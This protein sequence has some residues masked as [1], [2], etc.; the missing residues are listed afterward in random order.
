MR[1]DRPNKRVVLIVTLPI[2]ESPHSTLRLGGFIRALTSLVPDFPSRL[3]HF[4][5]LTKAACDSVDAKII[6][7]TDEGIEDTPIGSLPT[8]RLLHKK[9]DQRSAAPR[10]PV[11]LATGEAK[12]Q[13]VESSP[14]ATFYRSPLAHLIREEICEPAALQLFYE[15]R[16]PLKEIFLKYAVKPE[17]HGGAF[18]LDKRAWGK[19]AEDYGLISR[20]GRGLIAR[21]IFEEAFDA[22][23]CRCDELSIPLSGFVEAVATAF[24]WH[25][26]LSICS[27]QAE[28]SAL[29]KALFTLAFLHS[30]RQDSVDCLVGDKIDVDELDRQLVEDP[31]QVQGVAPCVWC[32]PVLGRLALE[33]FHNG[34]LLLSE[35]STRYPEIR[36]HLERLPKLNASDQEIL[37]WYRSLALEMPLHEDMAAQANITR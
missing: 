37:E 35:V 4:R 34:A 24:F 22:V 21:W 17:E 28:A 12:R 15:F 2:T 1:P 20:R 5:A 8:F 32:Y 29:E 9:V 14:T 3:D 26:R 25:L 31:S 7:D 6:L 13:A 18:T 19:L 30:S 11:Y 33:T 27:I 10:L 23:S 36:P 16:G